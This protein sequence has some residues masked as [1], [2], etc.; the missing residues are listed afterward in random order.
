MMEYR[1]GII[2]LLWNTLFKL[3][4]I[5][6]HSVKESWAETPMK[7]DNVLPVLD[8]SCRED[9]VNLKTDHSMLSQKSSQ[10]QDIFWGDTV[11]R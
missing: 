5:S 1:G 2:A 6:F 11:E 9:H 7:D 4:F 8:D 10:C 3:K